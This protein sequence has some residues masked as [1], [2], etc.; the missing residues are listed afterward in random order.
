MRQYVYRSKC[1]TLA[2]TPSARQ[3]VSFQAQQTVESGLALGLQSVHPYKAEEGAARHPSQWCLGIGSRSLEKIQVVPRV[4]E[5]FLGSNNLL[6]KA[7]SASSQTLLQNTGECRSSARINKH[8]ADPPVSFPLSR[9]QSHS[10]LPLFT[11]SRP[12]LR[13]CAFSK[14]MRSPRRGP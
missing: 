6:H 3:I 4:A 5:G 9:I 12:D 14:R 2:T 7:S 11:Q 8:S 13:A 10:R 1:L